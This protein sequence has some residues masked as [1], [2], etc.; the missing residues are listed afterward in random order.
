MRFFERIST[1]V[2]YYFKYSRF[3]QFLLLNLNIVIDVKI[4]ILSLAF[5]I[6]RSLTSSI[7]RI[8]FEFSKTLYISCF[9]IFT[10]FN[11]PITN[12]L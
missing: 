3:A 1:I 7:L 6:Y 8:F 12:L 4:N 5:D 11:S 10:I 9:V 2:I